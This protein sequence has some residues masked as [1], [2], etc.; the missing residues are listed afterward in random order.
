MSTYTPDIL[1]GNG[2]I[3]EVKGYFDSLDRAKH[4]LIKEQHPDLDIRFVFQKSDKKISKTSNTTYA[5][6][7]DKHGFMYA[8]GLIPID[9]LM[10]WASKVSEESVL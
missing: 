6:W 4:L 5:N 7:C 8:D 2:V 3:V 9:W 1:L 10:E